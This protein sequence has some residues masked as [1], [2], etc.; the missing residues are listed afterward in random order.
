MPI[1]E[2]YQKALKAEDKVDYHDMIIGATDL[3]KS[4]TYKSP[5]R[6]I[7]VDEFQ[8]ISMGRA[9]LLSALQKSD[10]DVQLF[11]VGD[12]WQAIYRFTGSDINIMKNFEEHFGTYARSDLGTTFRCE[13]KITDQATHFILQ[14]NF[15]IPKKVRSINEGKHP[16]VY[17]CLRESDAQDQLTS[18]MNVIATSE[19]VPD[20]K[21]KPSVLILGR[22]RTEVLESFTKTNY[23][24][25]LQR[26]RKSFDQL[27]I[28]YKTVHGSKGLEAD[29]VI[30]LDHGFPSE[31]VDDPILN[32]VLS[33]PEV[34]PNS[35]ERRLFYVALTRAKKKV[36]LATGS[37]KRSEF[38]DE[39]IKSPIDIEIFGKQLPEEPNCEK[40]VKG[41][42]KLTDGKKGKF[43][44]CKNYPYCKHREQACPFCK[45]GYPERNDDSTISCSVCEQ[46]IEKCPEVGCRGFI[47]QRQNKTYGNFFWGCTEYS[48]PDK[49]CGYTR[50]TKYPEDNDKS[51]YKKYSKNTSQS[52][53]RSK[54]P[55][56][57]NKQ[58]PNH[59]KPWTK[60]QNDKLK[61]LVAENKS[62]DLIAKEMGRSDRSIEVQRERLGL[63]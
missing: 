47:Q 63:Y 48:N 26:L 54:K 2:S 4:G 8:D 30:L 21:K 56:S 41:N 40:C 31:K 19:D 14:N 27:N 23:F 35:E 11:C 59:G 34:F 20:K 9:K 39:V 13:K 37:G 25:I 58:Y 5:Y 18:I 52:G 1:F 38:I 60:A 16:S 15:Q 6:Y 50:N 10:P 43:W 7:M 22:Y 55:N 33:A 3:I 24:H 49:K 46:Q 44:L 53:R 29:Y 61:K 36:F 42:L 12:D 28:N 45:N 62:T 17:V 57:F 51:R 32:M